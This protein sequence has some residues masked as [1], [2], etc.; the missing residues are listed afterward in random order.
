MTN[1]EKEL[2]EKNSGDWQNPMSKTT[3]KKK[4]NSDVR[5][6]L[7]FTQKCHIFYIIFFFSKIQCE[8]FCREFVRP[9]EKKSNDDDEIPPQYYW[10]ILSQTILKIIRFTWCALLHIHTLT[11]K[12]THSFQKNK[13]LRRNVKN[14]AHANSHS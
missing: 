5:I 12:N 10:M 13:S 7:I 11:Q 2:F 3:K 8:E 9:I 14:R 6:F 4:K 1:L